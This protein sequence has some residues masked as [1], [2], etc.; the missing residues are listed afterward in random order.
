[1][2]CKIICETLECLCLMCFVQAERCLEIRKLYNHD[3]DIKLTKRAESIFCKATIPG[4]SV[5]F[6]LYLNGKEK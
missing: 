2:S 4:T 1:M 6:C 5:G 3:E